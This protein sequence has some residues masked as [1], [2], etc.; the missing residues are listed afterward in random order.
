VSAFATSWLVHLAVGGFQAALV[1]AAALLLVRL[2]PRTSAVW[3]HAVLALALL[4][5][6][7][8]PMLPLPSGVFTALTASLRPAFDAVSAS[9]EGSGWALA[10][11][12]FH[13]A[14]ASLVAA[15]IALGAWRWRRCVRG[16]VPDERLVIVLGACARAAGWRRRLPQVRVAAELATPMAGGLLRPVVVVPAELART[17]SA[18]RLRLVLR[19]E[20]EHLARRDPWWNLLGGVLGVVWWWHPVLWWLLSA[21]R[22]VREERCDDAVVASAPEAVVEYAHALVDLAPRAKGAKGAAVSAPA[23]A[24][25][26]DSLEQRLRRLL[27]ERASRRTRVSRGARVALLAL[28]LGALPGLGFARIV[29]IRSPEGAAGITFDHAHGHTHAH[30]HGHAPQR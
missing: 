7:L 9:V 28:A 12:T 25:S 17:A 30:A 26:G 23:C 4:K 6:A 20:L 21:A 24:A 27:D 29:W 2:A 13:L 16:S 14:G 1:G 3:R 19:H 11:T 18:E 8:P 10:L 5:F 15:R 22:R